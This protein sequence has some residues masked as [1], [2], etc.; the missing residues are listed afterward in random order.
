MKNIDFPAS[1][2]GILL[3]NLGT[4][5]S[6]KSK[7]VKT[8]LQQ[9]LTDKYLITGSSLKR[10]FLVN[11]IIIPARL[12]KSTAAY[13][14][15]WTE[16]GSPL[17]TG[18]INV[19]ES[20]SQTINMPVNIAMRYGNPSIEAAFREFQEKE[21]N[22]IIIIPFYP[23]FTLSTY[24][25]MEEE[26]E[27]IATQY[28]DIKYK[29]TNPLALDKNYLNGFTSF[30]NEYIIQEI[31]ITEPENKERDADENISEDKLK[32]NQLNSDNTD[33]AGNA[34]P[35]EIANEISESDISEQ[36]SSESSEHKINSDIRSEIPFSS[37]EQEIFAE[38]KTI[39]SE[40]E[41]MINE[42]NQKETAEKEDNKKINVTLAEEKT[43]KEKEKSDNI[44]QEKDKV[45]HEPEIR[46]ETI[47]KEF[48]HILFSFHGVPV[49]HINIV[50]GHKECC[51]DESC[52]IKGLNYKCDKKCYW[53]QCHVTAKHILENSL[54]AGNTFSVAFQSRVGK[55]PW[56]EPDLSSTL[57]KLA[58]EGKKNILIIPA[59][60]PVDCVE[61]TYE[62]SKTAEE[63]FIS[64]GGKSFEILPALNSYEGWIESLSKIVES[65]K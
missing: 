36:G 3:V 24:V 2:T 16:E 9:M 56:I 17:K 37:F 25:T 14:S 26:I 1:D 44:N 20:L 47:K 51:F 12:S 55:T 4:P 65:Y 38:R 29:I 53:K 8:F 15:V 23:H 49:S 64:H 19:A 61:T 32:E 6:P 18:M 39:S 31:E 22:N 48:D 42:A 7:D 13:K 10:K 63:E 21:I 5:D 45:S 54:L 35:E 40:E 62:L 50:A 34:E 33:N 27:R 43:E 52:Q 46:K 30:I 57:Q 60:F 59:S 41:I 58:K 11:Y 28:K